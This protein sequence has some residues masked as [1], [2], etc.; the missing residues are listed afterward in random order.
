MCKEDTTMAQI[1]ALDA[2]RRFRIHKD[3]ID[4]H[5]RVIGAAGMGV[6]TVLARHAHPA[7]GEGRITIVQIARTLDMTS[8][9]VKVALRR[10]VD[11]SLITATAPELSA[12]DSRTGRYRLLDPSP[13][14]VSARLATKA[15][16]FAYPPSLRRE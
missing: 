7:T 5:G 1:L 3:L 13:T 12:E 15:K 4:T 16:Q 2:G 8:S 14:A 6:Y 9:E 11:A 10:L